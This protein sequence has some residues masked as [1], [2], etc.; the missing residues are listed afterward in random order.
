MDDTAEHTI[1]IA[2][3]Q[4]R[5]DELIHHVLTTGESVHIARADGQSV[6]MLPATELSSLLTTVH[7]LRSRSNAARLY[8]A[9]E[10]AQ[11]SRGLPVDLHI[12]RSEPHL[13][14][15]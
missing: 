6:A 4:A 1:S 14:N 5:F 7:L 2:D 13:H 10:Q 9:L 8:S 15:E 12:L 11:S 3:A